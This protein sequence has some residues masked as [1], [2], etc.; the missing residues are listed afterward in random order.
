LPSLTAK[1]RADAISDPEL[2]R[3]YQAVY[4]AFR[5]R[6]SLLLLNLESQVKLGEL[7]W[8]RAVEPWVGSDEATR[9]A[10]RGTLARAATLALSAVPE[11]IVPNKLVKEFRALARDAGLA[12]PLV[13]EL[14]ADIFMGAF[15]ENFLRAAQAAARL[16][17]GSLYERYYGLP[18]DRVLALDDLEDLYGVAISPGFAALCSELAGPAEGKG[19]PVAGNGKII[20]QEQIL[21]THNLATLFSELDL[22]RTLDLP[23]LARRAL[24]WI[25]GNQSTSI[26]HARAGLWKV[27]NSAY[28]WRQMIFYLSLSPSA[29]VSAFLEWGRARIRSQGLTLDHLEPVWN[30]LAEIARGERFGPDGVHAASGGRRFLGWSVGGHWLLRARAR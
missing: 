30:G 7:P 8:I 27:K 19:S 28:A 24:V 12:L 21:T 20:E 5:R 11:T 3:I 29:D 2:R 14:A 6:R 1:V 17:R 15:S 26:S 9:S 10:A 16:L 22:A 18:Y 23:D 25:C 4:V 13:D